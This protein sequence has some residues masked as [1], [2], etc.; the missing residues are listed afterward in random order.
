MK[1]TLSTVHH[2][3]AFCWYAFVVRSLA[4][5]DGEDLPPGIF[6]YGGPWKYL[7]FLNLAST[8]LLCIDL[9]VCW[10]VQYW[11]YIGIIQEWK[12]M[13]GWSVYV[14]ICACTILDIANGILWAGCC[15]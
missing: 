11:K 3:A 10:T 1:P 8:V 15:E 13:A 6:V 7:T 4:A 2:V 12:W 14:S 5:K 9:Y